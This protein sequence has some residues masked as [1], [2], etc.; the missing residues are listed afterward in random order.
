MAI[1]EVLMR[2]TIYGQQWINRFHYVTPSTGSPSG[3]GASDI[4]EAFHEGI[5]P[6]IVAL[7]ATHA[8]WRYQDLIATSLYDPTDFAEHLGKNIAGTAGA[9]EPMPP[10]VALAFRTP[11]LRVGQNRGYKRF[12]GVREVAITGGLWTGE[13]NT[14]ETNMINALGAGLGVPEG[15]PIEY[16]APAILFLNYEG[17]TEKG[18]RKYGFYP[19]ETQQR[20]NMVTYPSWD[21]YRVTSQR[22][23]M[24]GVGQ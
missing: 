14:P 24:S 16:A 13:G 12:C 23:R 1:Y 6:S 7:A 17:L 5:T 15:D 3:Y 18:R 2:G 9:N 22:S 11:R 19:T 21:F 10:F 4:L 8:Q 20:A